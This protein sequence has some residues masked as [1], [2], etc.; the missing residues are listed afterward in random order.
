MF[1]REFEVIICIALAV[2]TGLLF[3]GKGDFMLKTKD[4]S[5]KKRTPEEQLK[6]SKGLSAFTAMWLVAELG[7]MFLA[8]RGRWVSGAY[9]GVLILTFV[10]LVFYSKK[11]A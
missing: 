10:G 5:A 2:V 4:D 7:R 9:L 11:N 1:S 6:F 8:D 3:F